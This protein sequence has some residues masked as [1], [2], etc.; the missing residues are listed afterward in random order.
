MYHMY[1]NFH[2]D[3]HNP[4]DPIPRINRNLLVLHEKGLL[5]T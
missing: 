3:S 1:T 4:P 2:R 5:E